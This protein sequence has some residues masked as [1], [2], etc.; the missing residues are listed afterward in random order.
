M[1]RTWLK[2]ICIFVILDT[3]VTVFP[4]ENNWVGDQFLF[5]WVLWILFKLDIPLQII[6]E[7]TL[8]E[9]GG[10]MTNE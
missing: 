5:L 8:F 4:K 10:V 2:Q 3:H 6:V 9:K 1:S 7:Y